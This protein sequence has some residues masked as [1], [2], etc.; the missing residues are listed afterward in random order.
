MQKS[1]VTKALIA[2]VANGLATSQT[3]GGAASLVLAGSLTSGGVG[4]LGSQRRVI[5]TPSG[6]DAG[7]TWTV[8]G[9]DDTGNAI[10]DVF[11]GVNNPAVAQSNL[12]F[13]TVTSIRSSGATNGAVTAG[14]NGVGSSPWKLFTD[15]INTPNLSIN[16]QLVSGTGNATVEFTYDTFLPDTSQ[17]QSAIELAPASPNPQILPHPVLQGLTASK[18]GVIDWV[19]CGWRLTINSGTGTW[20]M[21]SQQGGLASP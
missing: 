1:V 13:A 17:P 15:T 21:T 8:I 9:T 3:L 14:T 12:N 19:V 18:D 5:I 20:K 6:N 16:A 2:G 11:S 4:I 7:I 10:K